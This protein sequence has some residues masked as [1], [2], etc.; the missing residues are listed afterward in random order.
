[1]SGADPTTPEPSRF[2]I[3]LPRSLWVVITTYVIVVVA[4]G[5]QFG[6]PVYRQQTAIWEIERM[7]G[8]VVTS[9][10]G[11]D[12]LRDWLGD[13]PMKKFDEVQG[14][15]LDGTLDDAGLERIS[16]LKDVNWLCLHETRITDAGLKH[17][18]NFRKLRRL[19]LDRT[20]ITG[21]GLEH[22]NGL[23]E[24]EVLSL[25]QT[26]VTDYELVNLEW[27]TSLRE[28]WVSGSNV[29]EIGAGD[30]KRTL[31]HITVHF[32][33]E[34]TREAE[35]NRIMKEEFARGGYGIH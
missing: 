32:A 24:L 23:T 2:A 10:R 27:M 4:V 25:E 17:I 9:K 33:E 21:S 8:R 3:R 20:Q 7:G 31:P 29:T 30:V 12:W 18:R 5:L 11:P 14:V 34:D 13:E 16:T 35:L 15:Y 1:M 6:V 19:E 26:R 28:L 22:L